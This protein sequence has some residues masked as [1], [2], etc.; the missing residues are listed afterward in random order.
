MSLGK[1][2][3]DVE[4]SAHAWPFHAPAP[5]LCP[6]VTPGTTTASQRK[7]KKNRNGQAPASPYIH[8]G[9]R[10]RQGLIALDGVFR[11]SRQ[12]RR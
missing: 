5:A 8:P 6:I 7:E 1:M 3:V 2:V 12:S 11:P 9:E 10:P 4:D